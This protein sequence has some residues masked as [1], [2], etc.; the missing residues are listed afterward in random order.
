MNRVLDSPIAGSKL[1]GFDLERLN[2][3]WDLL[4]SWT[5]SGEVPAIA[6]EIGR[7][8][9]TVARAFGRLRL[10]DPRRLP[11]DAR[12]LVASLVKPIVA[13]GVLILV[14][15][16]RLGLDDRVC[17]HVPEFAAEGKADVLVRHLLTHTS[18]LPDQL[19]ESDRLRAENQ[20]LSVFVERTCASPLLFAPGTRSRYQ[21]MGTLMLAEIAR[22]LTG[23]PLRDWLDQEIFRPLG[24]DRTSLGAGAETLPRIARI[25]LSAEQ[26]AATAWNWNSPY[27]LTLGAPWGGLI[28][29]PRDLGR[30][31]RMIA[32]QG[33]LDGV[34]VLAPATVRAMTTNQLDAFPDIDESERRLRPWGYGWRLHRPGDSA[35]FGDLLGPRSFGHH[36]ATGC[37]YWI[38]PDLDA[39]VVLLTTRPAGDDGRYLAL[40]SNAIAASILVDDIAG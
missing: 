27:W 38:D 19:P 34:R 13:A 40:A 35:F 14:E 25:A 10:D 26:E 29:D 6:L 37:L 16:G 33:S 23:M 21:S 24:M 9:E 28:S 5:R 31:C 8:R 30:F 15:R 11:D 18:G 17:E 3:A 22:R 4:E 2:R 39:Y 36:G 1:S 12:F 7:G 32:A 20:P